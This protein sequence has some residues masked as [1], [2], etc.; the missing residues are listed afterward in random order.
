MGA[1]AFPIISVRDLPATRSFYEQL[2]FSQA[3]Q[4]PPDGEPGFVTKEHGTAAIGIAAA[5]ADEERFRLLGVPG[6]RRPAPPGVH[7]RRRSCR[8]PREAIEL[9]L[10]TTATPEL[11]RGRG[12]TTSLPTR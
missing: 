2:G 12:P 7:R 8:A 3:Y 6:R 11:L 9:E 1:E 4:F 5:G 10:G